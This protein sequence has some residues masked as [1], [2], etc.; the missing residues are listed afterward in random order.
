MS[1]DCPPEVAAQFRQSAEAYEPAP[2]T[3]HSRQL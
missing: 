3:T 1:D 2:L